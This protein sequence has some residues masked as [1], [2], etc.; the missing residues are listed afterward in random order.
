[1]RSYQIELILYTVLALSTEAVFT[2]IADF[3]QRLWRALRRDSDSKRLSRLRKVLAKIGNIIQS[4][5]HRKPR[6]VPIK[7]ADDEIDWTLPCRTSLWSIPVYAISAT[8]AFNV[9]DAFWPE[10]FSLS[11]WERGLVY[12]LCT[13]SFEYVWGL[14]LEELTG[15]C[16]WRYRDS[17]WRIWRYI[18]PEYVLL[19]FGFGFA[20]EWVHL[21]AL[22]VAV[23][24]FS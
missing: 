12:T 13:F 21:E 1:M 7:P 9:M 3:I 20:L 19:W 4:L 15:F 5:A 8:F 2:G 14:I 22:P 11:W 6:G 18:N 17:K 16:P 10:F 24:A 23:L